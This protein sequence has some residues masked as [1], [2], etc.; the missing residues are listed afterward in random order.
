MFVASLRN[1]IR[2][3]NTLWERVVTDMT[4]DQV[5]HHERDGVLPIAFSLNHYIRA[6]DQSISRVFLGE[7]ELWQTGGWAG[8]VGVTID[9]LGREESV[10]EMEHIRFAD[11]DAWRAY[12]AQVLDRTARV[13][14]TLTEER[15]AEVVLPQLPPNMR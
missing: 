11:L 13:L 9:R 8:K 4:L 1:R 3:M 5:N 10:E 12:Q 2:A 14:D 15:L 6:Q 7:P